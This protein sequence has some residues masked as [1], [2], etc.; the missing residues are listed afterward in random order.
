MN[1]TNPKPK[2]HNIIGKIKWAF[3]FDP[4]KKWVAE[5]STA[6]AEHEWK[7][8]LV[9][10]ETIGKQVREMLKTSKVKNQIK[11]EK[12]G[13]LVLKIAKKTEVK[14]KD[15]TTL[16][17]VAPVVTDK[18]GRPW[19]KAN[20]IGN[21]SLAAITIQESHFKTPYGNI[22]RLSLF[23]VQILEHVS[24]EK[25]AGQSTPKSDIIEDDLNF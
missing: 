6:P 16:K 12:D 14:K 24:Y 13:E 11:E 10:D 7:L 17:L 19:D 22:S 5:G 23:S 25:K 9:V 4:A 20:I 3:L 8:S 1:N 2:Y 18:D 15:G 21:G